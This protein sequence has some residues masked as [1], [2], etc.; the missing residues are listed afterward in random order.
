MN[1]VTLADIVRKWLDYTL[2][3]MDLSASTVVS[4]RRVAAHLV[5]WGEDKPV[6]GLDLAPYAV[7]RREA[8]LAP[9]T[10]ALELRIVRILFKWAQ[11]QRHIPS[12]ITLLCPRLK[13]DP[14]RFVL[15]H[16]TPSPSEVSKVL[17]AMPQDDFRT[18]AVVLARTGAR[19]GEVVRLRACD[20]DPHG[21]MVTFGN[22]DG[23]AKSG[24][25]WFPVDAATMSLLTGRNVKGK[26]PLFQFDGVTA[27]IQALERRILKACDEAGVPRFTPHGLRRMVISRLMRSRVDPGTAASLTGHSV[28]VMLR[29]YQQVTDGDRRAAVEVANL[30]ELV[31]ADD[32]SGP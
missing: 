6:S 31:D 29:Y 17:D 16:R 21:Q 24:A 2:H 15:N 26:M 9:R 12:T 27:P 23:A 4:Y 14:R 25:R 20:L 1:E 7:L 3:R 5:V 22:V 32:V 28:Q 11:E 13:V 8:G 19:I 18:V 10:L 30:T